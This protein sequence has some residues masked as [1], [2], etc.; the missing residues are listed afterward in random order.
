MRTSSANAVAGRSLLRIPMISALR[1]GHLGPGPSPKGTITLTTIT[2]LTFSTGDGTNDTKMVF[3][4]TKAAINAALATLK[5]TPHG[6]HQHDR[7]RQR[8][9]IDHYRR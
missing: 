8:T 1:E 3:T 4:G 6:Q 5:F 2:G 9:D 7:R